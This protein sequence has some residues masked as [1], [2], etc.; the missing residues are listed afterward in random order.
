MKFLKRWPVIAF[1]FLSAG[2]GCLAMPHLSVPELVKDSTLIVVAQVGEI[3]PVAPSAVTF[4]GDVLPGERYNAE[5]VALYTLAGYNPGRFTI[6]FALPNAGN[7]YR[8]LRPGVRML[9]LKRPATN[10][11]PVNLYYPDL[12][13]L[14]SPPAE[15]QGRTVVEQVFAVLGAVVASPDTSAIDRRDVLL[16]SYAIP[17]DNKVFLQDLIIGAHNSADPS[18]HWWIQAELINRNDLS[19]FQEVVDALSSGNVPSEEERKVLYAIGT[20]LTNAKALPELTKMLSAP[21]PE[22]RAAAA[23][24]TWHIASASSVDTLVRAL[25]DPDSEVRYYAIRGLDEITGQP[26]W[27]PGPEEYKEHE[28]KYLQHWLDWAANLSTHPEN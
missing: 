10:Y 7:T 28:A 23:Q 4:N 9:F 15:L 12:P 1:G 26:G 16:W 17:K 21:Q 2:L 18:V 6:E 22:L 14:P 5:A 20:R 8:S 11:V 13:A 24:A 19:Q 27:G 25:H 3:R